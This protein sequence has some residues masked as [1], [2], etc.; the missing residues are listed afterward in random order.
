MLPRHTFTRFR[1]I[2]LTGLP[3]VGKTSFGKAY[4]AHTYRTFVDLDAAIEKEQGRSIAQIFRRDGEQ[5]FREIELHC[6]RRVAKEENVVVALG[7]GA[8]QSDEAV[9]WVKQHGLLVH[10]ECDLPTLASRLFAEKEKRPLISEAES[11]EQVSAILA[12]LM[13]Q[14]GRYYQQ[15]HV[16]LDL[17]YSTI[18][19]AKL[20]LAAV[21]RRAFTKSRDKDHSAFGS[22][23]SSVPV[24]SVH[25]KR[26]YVLREKPYLGAVGILDSAH[27]GRKKVPSTKGRKIAASVRSKRSGKLGNEATGPDENRRLPHPQAADHVRPHRGRTEA[28]ERADQKVR[29][30]LRERSKRPDQAETGVESGEEMARNRPTGGRRRPGRGNGSS[31]SRLERP[32]GGPGVPAGDAQQLHGGTLERQNRP[33]GRKENPTSPARSSESKPPSQE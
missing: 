20:E 14:R 24:V 18:D 9:E 8:L 21:E 30:G 13:E 22:D 27:K 33:E 12:E 2:L 23:W 29:P 26:R 3:G 17:R 16:S 4:A 28:G 11:L 6:L 15:S 19:N 5:T 7:G 25:A 10:L 31:R 32:N 1:C